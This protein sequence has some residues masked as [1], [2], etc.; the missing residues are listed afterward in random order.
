[1]LLV[2]KS[3]PNNDP[4]IYFLREIRT[5]NKKASF[6]PFSLATPVIPC[7]TSVDT[8]NLTNLKANSV[9]PDQMSKMG[10]MIWIYRIYTVY[11]W[12]K[13]ISHGVMGQGHWW[14]IIT[15]YSLANLS[16]FKMTST[17]PLMLT[18]MLNSWNLWIWTDMLV[19]LFVL[20]NLS[21]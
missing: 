21:V 8:T 10:E 4:N 2:N 20:Q 1:M 19:C 13:A 9:T 11:P 7:V 12:V 17:D 3:Q 16:D 14:K 18:T 5:L 15:C 6:N